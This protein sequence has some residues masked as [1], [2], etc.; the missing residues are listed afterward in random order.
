MMSLWAVILVLARVI[1]PDSGPVISPDRVAVMSPW[2]L[3]MILVEIFV[4]PLAAPGILV[5]SNS[6]PMPGS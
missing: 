4:I 2:L 1:K 5:R 6:L 3:R